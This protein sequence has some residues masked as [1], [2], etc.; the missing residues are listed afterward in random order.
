VCSAQGK[1]ELPSLLERARL[2][3]DSL[4]D[5]RVCVHYSV[6]ANYHG[7]PEA[8]FAALTAFCRQLAA[9]PR[10]SLLLVSGGG[11]RK[12]LDSLRA[13]ELA[14]SSPDWRSLRLPLAVAFNPFF[15]DAE[16]RAQERERLR[17]KLLAARGR[18]SAVYLQ[19]GS[20]VRRLQEGLVFLRRLLDEVEGHGDGLAGVCQAADEEQPGSSARPSPPAPKRQ[21]R[22][23]QQGDE[24]ERGGRVQVFGSVFV[25]SRKLLA[26]M[27]FRP[28]GGVFLRQAAP[29][30]LAV[31]GPFCG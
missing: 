23:Q 8:G 9:L 18:V 25:P 24:Q 19:A 6:N 3:H 21:R 12:R 13:L 26:A 2:L 22:H 11:P 31:R 15:P 28:W 14:A 7:G 16:R 27:R 17:G 4:P 30:P 5:A 1:G 29:R 20:D 10:C